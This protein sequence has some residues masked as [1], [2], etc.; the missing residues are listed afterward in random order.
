V[1]RP[2]LRR[3][4]TPSEIAEELDDEANNVAGIGELPVR[5]WSRV[6]ESAQHDL[7]WLIDPGTPWYRA[8][9]NFVS[10]L[11]VFSSFFTPLQFAFFAGEGGKMDYIDNSI[12]AVFVLDM[13]LVLTVA[14]KVNET[15]VVDRLVIWRNYASSSRMW[16][17]MATII[18]GILRVTLRNGSTSSIIGVLGLLRIARLNR[19]I[20]FFQELQK[21]TRLNLLS[22]V[23]SKFVLFILLCT[24]TSGCIFYGLARLADYNDSSW[25]H[26]VDPELPQQ[27][28]TTR[29]VHVLYWGVGTFKAGPASGRIGPMSNSEMLLACGA[30]MVNICL[31][32]YLVSNMAALLTAADVSIY[33]MRNKFSQLTLFCDRYDLSEKLRLHLKSYLRFKFATHQD[34]DNNVLSG[35][36]ELYRQRISH[37][38][39]DRLVSR[40]FIFK[41]CGKH[42]LLHLHC[43]LNSSMHMPHHVLIKE[44]EPSSEL[45][46]LSEGEVFIYFQGDF[47][48]DR[49]AGECLTAVPF[50]CNVGQPFD[51]CTGSRACRLISLSRSSWDEACVAYPED[52]GCVKANLLTECEDK[53]KQFAIGS[54]GCEAYTKLTRIVERHVVQQ[55]E[56]TTGALCFAAGRGSIQEM[57]RF[58]GGHSANCADYDRRSPLHI[59][60]ANGELQAIELL[61]DKKASINIVDHF[62]RTP[63]V[64]ACRSRQDAAAKLLFER[65]ARLGF[66][67]GEN[68]SETEDRHVEAGELC[69]AASDPRQL[70][71]LSALL[72]YGAVANVGDYDA[73]TA[74]HVACASGNTPAVE[75]LLASGGIDANVK[76]NFGRTPLMEAVRHR[77][78]PCARLLQAHG[79]DHGFCVDP[80]MSSDVNAVHAGQELCQAAFAN[81]TAYLHSLV[82]LCGIFVDAADYDKRTALMLASAEG[83]M[84]AAVSLM[85]L[86]ADAHR[87]DRWGH[88][89]VSEARDSGHKNLA[90]V[91]EQL[92]RGRNRSTSR[93]LTAP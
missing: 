73:R 13:L 16:I 39:Y 8:W 66:D 63:L 57:S 4:T 46:V 41:D 11:V 44:S 89:A 18:P 52:V 83:N 33:A 9:T 26:M 77:Q 62:G 64:E 17:D 74:L 35:F 10:L 88:T 84:D 67:A 87:K 65:G 93:R 29:Y 28:W 92:Q 6:G 1:D 43:A 82:T 55:R 91:L 54:K 85:Q 80:K 72:K 42:F 40:I 21:N 69:Q 53:V 34:L 3:G 70:W 12:D 81:Q 45:Q 50:I 59:A 56:A 79:A 51:V 30:M 68:D 19:I 71:Y 38:L 32:T 37:A 76:D 22:V 7:G 78:E 36:P 61:I 31:Q 25:V 47:L 75:I 14:I 27:S 60:A 2:V 49:A 58:L 86:G 23:V 5:R 15:F 48:E 20:M 24:H 90:E